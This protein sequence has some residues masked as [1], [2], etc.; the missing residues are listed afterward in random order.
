MTAEKRKEL[1]FTS[2]VTG[3]PTWA[4][5]Q[6]WKDVSTRIS[7][8]SQCHKPIVKKSKRIVM[9]MRRTRSLKMANGAII[10]KD[11]LFFHPACIYEA[12]KLPPRDRVPLCSDCGK[13]RR[14]GKS[15]RAFMN[16]RYTHG[17]ICQQCAESKA[18]EVCAHC[19]VHYPTYMVQRTLLQRE[20]WSLACRFCV[21]RLGLYT[22]ADEKR[23]NKIFSVYR[24][25]ILEKLRA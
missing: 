2:P 14:D 20:E 9:V 11:R 6:L 10:N 8:C 23:D 18:W 19:L 3:D 4:P 12:M 13:A 24:R 5:F 17:T 16:K 1:L 15:Y 7:N 25:R 22:T 21:D